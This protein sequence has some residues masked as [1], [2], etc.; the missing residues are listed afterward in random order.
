MLSNVE[1]VDD[2][3]LPLQI[4]LRAE[5][6]EIANPLASDMHL[7]EHLRLMIRTQLTYRP[8]GLVHRG[9]LRLGLNDFQSFAP[10]LFRANPTNVLYRKVFH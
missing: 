8:S 10:E 9:L 1:I 5:V 3:A 4:A 2:K 7:I 6:D